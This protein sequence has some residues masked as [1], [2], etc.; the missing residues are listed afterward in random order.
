MHLLAKT[1][2]HAEYGADFGI[3]KPRQ[4][5]PEDAIFAS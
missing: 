5:D 3:D 1:R 4:Y 2:R